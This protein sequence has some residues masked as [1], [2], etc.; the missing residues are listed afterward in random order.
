MIAS[1]TAAPAFTL[2]GL[3][4]GTVS[5]D[6]DS[7]APVLVAFYKVTCPVCEYTFPF[8]ERIAS[9][10]NGLRVL[11]ISQNGAKETA[12]FCRTYGLRFP[13]GLDSAE[14]GYPA[15]NAYRI[16]HV[17]SLFLVENG[18]ITMSVSGFSRADLEQI[19]AR[20]GAPPFRKGEKIPDFRPG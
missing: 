19:G 17:P 6:S 18:E 20:F 2:P 10:A 11:G 3:S 7:G 14:A 12:A 15:S 8:L 13:M 4:G 16:T 9:G 5:L 1:G